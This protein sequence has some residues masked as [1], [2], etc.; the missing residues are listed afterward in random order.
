MG[1]EWL[2]A[3]RGDCPGG[4]A[5]VGI[6]AAAGVGAQVGLPRD[7]PQ[8]PAAAAVVSTWPDFAAESGAIFLTA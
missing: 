5:G 8:C 3:G 6:Q 7:A 1:G 2:T 4:E